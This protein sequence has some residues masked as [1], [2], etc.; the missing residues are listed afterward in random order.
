[1]I[2]LDDSMGDV[3]GN[4]QDRL[5][6]PP[7]L[8]LAQLDQAA[9]QRACRVIQK[10]QFLIIGE[11]CS[12]YNQLDSNQ[13]SKISNSILYFCHFDPTTYIVWPGLHCNALFN[14][15]HLQYMS[16]SDSGSPCMWLSSHRHTPVI[17]IVFKTCE[18][19]IDFF[20]LAVI[21]DTTRIAR[22]Q[23]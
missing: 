5:G 1:M 22:Q 18:C 21:K 11:H 13:G 23:N 8:E 14:V 9:H 7:F 16:T 3:V 12:V 17:S 6:L 15:H 2:L 20:Q 19:C 10:Y 4:V